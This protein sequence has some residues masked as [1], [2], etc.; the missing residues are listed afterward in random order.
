MRAF[1]IPLLAA[2]T[3]AIVVPLQDNNI[4]LELKFPRVANR[5]S[6]EYFDLRWRNTNTQE[7]SYD[8]VK[9]GIY[10]HEIHVDESTYLHQLR[11][12]L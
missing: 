3:L 1:L 5:L 12:D 4:K 2:A 9:E 8:Q 10:K 7:M 11:C 6:G